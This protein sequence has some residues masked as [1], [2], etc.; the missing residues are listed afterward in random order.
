LP[1]GS[2][3]LLLDKDAGDADSPSNTV[4]YGL[5]SLM[6]LFLPGKDI[7]AVFISDEEK[8]TK[9]FNDYRFHYYWKKGSLVR[10]N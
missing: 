7:N 6:K 2:S 8:F 10:M 1:A 9:D 5:N 4:S 3:I